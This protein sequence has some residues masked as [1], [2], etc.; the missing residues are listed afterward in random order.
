LLQYS[1]SDKTAFQI[2]R[3]STCAFFATLCIYGLLH[4]GFYLTPEL[5]T[6]ATW[7]V[8]VQAGIAVCGLNRR[9][10]P[11]MALGIL[12]LYFAA[13]AHYGFYHLLDY[14][15]FPGI[16]YFLLA[17]QQVSAR[18]MRSS[19]M[20]LYS[21]TGLTLLWDSIEK[22]AS[23]YWSLPLLVDSPALRFGLPPGFFLT[24]SGFVEFCLT[25][26]MLCSVSF[27]A[28]IVPLFLAAVFSAAVIK[29]GMIDAVGHLPFAAVL[30]VLVLRGRPNGREII[31]FKPSSLWS[32]AYF[33]TGIY[34]LALNL[35]FIAYYG[36]HF[37]SYG[38]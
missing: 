25:F 14:V 17:S 26:V 37:V 31:T 11:L 22:W 16:A 27:M 18:W 30:I 33:M 7:V 3:W 5:Q 21:T 29:F 4:H 9:G 24:A 6:D 36:L 15:A 12:V 20:V 32:D 28:R 10:V 8:W 38:N 23:P 35:I 1:I 13:A 2:V 19:F 34:C